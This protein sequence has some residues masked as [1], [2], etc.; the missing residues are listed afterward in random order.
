MSVT[1]YFARHGETQ[2]NVIGL[3]QGWCDSPLTSAGIYD[4]YRLG[5]GLAGVEFVGA[6]ASDALRARRTLSIALEARENERAR[7]RCGLPVAAD[8]I[9]ADE[10]DALFAQGD[11]SEGDQIAAIEEFLRSRGCLEPCSAVPDTDDASDIARRWLL[12]AEAWVPP[13]AELDRVSYPAVTLAA[14]ERGP[15]AE[16]SVPARCDA[17]LREWCFG[18]LDGA[19]ARRMRNRLFDL[20]G[21]DLPREQQN[22]R[23]DEIADYLAAVDETCQAENFATIA[24]RLRSFIDDCARSVEARGGGNVLVVTHAL[25][26]RTL[27]FLYARHRVASPG[28]IENASIT[29]AR[30]DAGAVTVESVGDTSYLQRRPS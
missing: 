30:W 21:D 1:F 5:Q 6:C 10:A 17:R 7:L 29:T 24:A 25:L 26:I 15:H 20:F 13:L 22:E 8:Q 16:P 14:L 9:K 12:E 28:K 11:I 2:F 18:D 3:V 23:L 19:P 27:V 4:A